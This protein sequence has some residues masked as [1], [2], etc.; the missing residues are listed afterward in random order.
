MSVEENWAMK[1]ER[2]KSQRLPHWAQITTF[3]LSLA[4]RGREALLERSSGRCEEQTGGGERDREECQ[5]AE[6]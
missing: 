5:W 1:S 2:I 3:L 6:W 4:C